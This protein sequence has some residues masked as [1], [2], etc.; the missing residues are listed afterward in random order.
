[1]N[2]TMMLTCGG[3][4][5]SELFF[6]IYVILVLVYFFCFG[7]FFLFLLN[8]HIVKRCSLH[9]DDADDYDMHDRGKVLV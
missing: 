9:E 7:L 6:E 2:L 4:K 5:E 8:K 3:R 1:M